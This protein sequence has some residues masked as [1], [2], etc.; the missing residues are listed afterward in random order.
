[1]VE[2]APTKLMVLMSALVPPDFLEQI[3]KLIPVPVHHVKMEVH[4][5][6]IRQE[7]LPSMFALASMAIS[8]LTAKMN[9]VVHIFA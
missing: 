6:L 9:H 7:L 2:L 5:L 3:V 1:M 4:V 8:V